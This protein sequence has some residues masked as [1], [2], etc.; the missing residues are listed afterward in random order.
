[1]SSRRPSVQRTQEKARYNQPWRGVESTRI[2]KCS[3]R[4]ARVAKICHHLKFH[5]YYSPLGNAEAHETAPAACC[6]TP[7][8]LRN[9]RITPVVCY[10]S[11]KTRKEKTRSITPRMALAVESK[12]QIFQTNQ[13]HKTDTGSP[14]VQIALLS[15]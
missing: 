13:R 3:H 1:M 10:L 12:R 4:N 15:G 14:E 2:P 7:K 11:T 6:S 5:R 8:S 9:R